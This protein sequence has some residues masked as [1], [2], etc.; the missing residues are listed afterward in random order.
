MQD[1]RT[2]D[3]GGGLA[4]RGGSWV[5]ERPRRIEDRRDSGNLPNG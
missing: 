2:G 5:W 4:D 1:I 3:R